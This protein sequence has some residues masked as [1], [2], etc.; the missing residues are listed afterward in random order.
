MT[1]FN[2]VFDVDGTLTP[3]RKSIDPDFAVFFLEFCQSHPVFLVSGSDY[4]KTVEQL[5]ETIC[6]SVSGVYSCCGNALYVQGRLQYQNEFSLSEYQEEE[7]YQLLFESKFP[8]K[9]GIHVEKR[10]GMVNFS[11]VGRNANWEQRQLYVEYDKET[12]ER[13]TLAKI[14]ERKFPKL[15]AT[16]GGETGLDIHPVGWDKSQ[17]A[18]FV[19]PFVFFG[20]KIAPGGNDY[21]IAMLADKYHAVSDWPETYAL[22]REYK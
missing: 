15:Q 13:E 22:L 18:E 10:L 14:I 20:D 12:H 16:L 7:L 19:K 17:I 3:S 6:N 9:T 1:D 21:T 4:K 2:F 11:I 5:G 8:V